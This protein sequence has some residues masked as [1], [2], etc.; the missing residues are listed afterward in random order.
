MW[1]RCGCLVMC[2]SGSWPTGARKLHDVQVL[3]LPVDRPRPRTATFTEAMHYHSAV[4]SA[5]KH[6]YNFSEHEGVTPYMALLAA[7]AVVLARVSGQTD[8]AVGS[9]L[10]SHRIASWKD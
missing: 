10:R 7:L 6:V 3:Q 1:Q 8:I 2:W 5:P 9:P 4:R